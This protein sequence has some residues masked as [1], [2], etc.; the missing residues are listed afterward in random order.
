M[1]KSLIVRSP[2][3]VLSS[4]SEFEKEDERGRKIY[5]EMIVKY[6]TMIPSEFDHYLALIIRRSIQTRAV[7]VLD[8]ILDTHSPNLLLS[9]IEDLYSPEFIEQI[10]REKKYMFAKDQIIRVRV[11]NEVVYEVIGVKLFLR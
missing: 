8:A 5:S 10:K 6:Y 11:D 3:E 9:Q 1:G 7:C 2:Q 4:L